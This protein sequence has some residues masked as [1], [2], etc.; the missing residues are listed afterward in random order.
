MKTDEVDQEMHRREQE[1]WDSLAPQNLGED[2]RLSPEETLERY[3]LESPVM[4]GAA[5]F[6][7]DLAGQR[8]L[9]VGCGL[10]K[11][12]VLLARERSTLVGFD[13]SVRSAAVARER[14]ALNGFGDTSGF[15]A[16]A[17]EHLP[18]PDAAFDV[19]VAKAVLHHLPAE[20]TSAELLRVLKPGGKFLASEPLGMNPLLDFAR[21]HLPY[22]GKHPPG[23]DQPLDYEALETWGA[24][25]SRYWW[26][27]VQLLSMLERARGHGTRMY[28]LRRLD[29]WLLG[30]FPRLRRYC[31]YA[32]IYGIK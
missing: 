18:F 26:R 31:R 16:S 11:L 20:V 12:S 25:F 29:S 8:I 19:V 22:P 10:G 3:A 1:K 14:T 23:D 24:G 28:R 32:V 27:E 13:I 15:L 17:A 7:G 30:R 21:D 2:A 9:E 5:D 6:L 4:V